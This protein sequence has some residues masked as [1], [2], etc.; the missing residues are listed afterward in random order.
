MSKVTSTTR[1]SGGFV[2]LL[3]GLGTYL[4]TGFFEGGFFRGLFQGATI[5]LMVLAAYFF[6]REIQDRR[7]SGDA[8]MWRPSDRD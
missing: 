7:R 2:L 3:L 5:A 4:A 6:G 8:P 1:L